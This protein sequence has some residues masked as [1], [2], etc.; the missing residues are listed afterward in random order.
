M[1]LLRCGNKL[2]RVG[3]RLARDTPACRAIVC[4]AQ[5]YFLGI[6]CNQSTPV[7]N[8]PDRILFVNTFRC[9]PN[10]DPFFGVVTYRGYCYQVAG[11]MDHRPENYPGVPI[12]APAEIVCKPAGVTCESTDCLPPGECCI[13]AMTGCSGNGGPACR[14]CNCPTFASYELRFQ[15]NTQATVFDLS[16]GRQTRVQSGNGRVLY[17]CVPGAGGAASR[18]ILGGTETYTCS[19][20]QPFFQCLPCNAFANYSGPLRILA[21]SGNLNLRFGAIPFNLLVAQAVIQCVLSAG[22]C[23]SCHGVSTFNN[24]CECSGSTPGCLSVDQSTIAADCFGGSWQWSGTG[25]SDTVPPFQWYTGTGSFS[26]QWVPLSTCDTPQ[27]LL[28]GEPPRK[29]AK[30]NRLTFSQIIAEIRRMGRP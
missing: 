18:S 7:P 16:G 29:V 3:G 22:G 25:V 10:A 6:R 12:A 2:A 30:V 20:V 17:Q 13:T 28:V 24:N 11:G 5:G 21:S 4:Q 14:P 9:S 15:W 8:V 23:T 19:T 27:P 26:W 1:K